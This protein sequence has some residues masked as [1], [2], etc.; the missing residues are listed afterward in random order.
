[1]PLSA[2][3][4]VAADAEAP[5]ACR[6][7]ASASNRTGAALPARAAARAPIATSPRAVRCGLGA[8]SGQ[9]NCRNRE[10]GRCAATPRGR[11]ARGSCVA[12]AHADDD[13][14]TRRGA[15]RS[16]GPAGRA[17]RPAFCDAPREAHTRWGRPQDATRSTPAPAISSTAA[18]FPGS[19]KVR[20]ASEREPAVAPG[21][22]RGTEAAGARPSQHA[23][24][25]GSGRAAAPT[26][27]CDA[28]G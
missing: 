5:L 7:S 22:S 9:A 4:V 12:S 14:L 1:M 23:R 28:P 10:F 8:D 24:G 16:L 2:A 13:E 19:N 11:G 21:A 26:A 17:V 20:I 3:D 15:R 18:A 25:P 6:A 27:T